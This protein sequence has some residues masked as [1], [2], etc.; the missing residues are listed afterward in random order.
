MSLPGHLDSIPSRRYT[1]YMKQKDI[2]NTTQTTILDAANTV[3]LENGADALTL[4]AVAE[5]AGIS[6]GGLLYHFPSKKKL[7]EGMIKRMIAEVDAALENELINN[8]GDYVKAYIHASFPDDP[9]RSEISAALFA[10]VANDMGLIEPLR[11][12]F[13]KMQEEIAAAAISPEIGTI[14]RLALDGLWVSDLFGFAPPS[15]EMREKM[16]TALLEIVQK[17]L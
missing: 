12:R 5:T 16:R 1:I 11:A 3:I 7:I 4:S 10:V 15:A 14:L 17:D 13:F 8:G 9:S 2:S 6:K